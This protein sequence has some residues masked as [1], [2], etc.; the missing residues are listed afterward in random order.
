MSS[1]SAELATVPNKVVED[2][3][4]E[5][6]NGGS[7]GSP[8]PQL[9]PA[10]SKLTIE[11]IKTVGDSVTGSH[12]AKKPSF[13]YGWM[14]LPL[15]IATLIASSPGQTFGIS[16]FNEPIRLSLGLSHSE[17]AF[18]YMLG[19]LLGAVPITW[20]GRQIDR[21]GLRKVLLVVVSLFSSACLM[22]GLVN[23]WWT[24]VPAFFML[25]MLG[26]GS[27]SLISNSTLPFWFM[28]R[29]GTV[30]GVRQMGMAIA[31]TI[32]PALNLWLVTHWG[33]RISYAILGS[34]T[35]LILFPA[36]YFFFR[37]RPE[38]VGQ[39]IDGKT[40]S[41]KIPPN[42]QIE[43]HIE[44]GGLEI[45]RRSADQMDKSWGVE[46]SA[47][48]RQSTFWIAASGTCLFSFVHTAL[49]F[50][51][52]PILSEQGLAEVDAA[53]LMTAFAFSMIF[54]QL[55]G[56]VLA[57]RFRS[58]YLLCVGLLLFSAASFLTWHAHSAWLA[59]AAG[60]LMG[61]AQG[62]YFGTNHPI[63]PRHFGLRYLGSIR[64]MLM[65][66][67]VATS[68]LGPLTAGLIRDTTGS[69]DG[70][71]WLFVLAPLPFAFWSL[72]LGLPPS[73]P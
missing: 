49:F 58:S 32:I 56:G 55:L 22:T 11:K 48:L 16:I 64:G 63:W 12:S 61:V 45:D 14:M 66:L 38:D 71:M 57:D 6:Q 35:W 19:T 28:R 33:W 47:A 69:F 23:S 2:D 30:E 1:T 31:M 51:V 9:V 53:K 54:M 25:R 17:L 62:I 40:A 10:E 44:D 21:F 5:P 52:V 26:S 7:T 72:K 39:S 50:Y 70:A 68:S 60:M 18:A 4:S 8:F 24:L 27:L 3:E 20:I 15:A 42:R 73:R 46:L 43:D 67:N 41:L 34:S 37:N 59:I 36:V 65:T 29:L 13:F